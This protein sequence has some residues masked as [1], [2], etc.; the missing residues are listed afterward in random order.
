VPFF[1][2]GLRGYHEQD[3][4]GLAWYGMSTFD[5]VGLYALLEKEGF[6]SSAFSASSLS[7][8]LLHL[9]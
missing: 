8:N 9:V 2:C 1:R 6:H 7:H 3:P 5:L 4:Y